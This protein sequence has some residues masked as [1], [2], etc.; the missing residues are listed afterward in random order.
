MFEKLLELA[1]QYR[2]KNQYV[3]EEFVYLRRVFNRREMK[4]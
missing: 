4:Y 2:R 1:E 3:E